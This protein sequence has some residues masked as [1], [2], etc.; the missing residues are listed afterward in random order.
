MTRL[1]DDRGSELADL[2][3]QMRTTVTPVI[4]YLELISHNLES[5]EPEN[6]ERWISTIERRMDAMHEL[7]DQ[8][9]SVCAEL[10][11]PGELRAEAV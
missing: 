1:P 10:R 11:G 5:A 9:S 3:E 2:A 8:I 6:P 4:G 7:H